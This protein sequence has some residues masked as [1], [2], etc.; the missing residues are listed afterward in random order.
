ML[1]GKAPINSANKLSG[2]TD[3]RPQRACCD[4]QD[5][6]TFSSIKT[7]PILSMH[8]K[9]GQE[10]EEESRNKVDMDEGIQSLLSSVEK[11]AQARFKAKWNFDLEI[12]E[13][14]TSAIAPVCMWSVVRQ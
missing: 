13:P 5:I 12:G 9:A 6:T 4:Q 7:A 1:A 10:Q 8:H 3:I 14:D 11:Q 2:V